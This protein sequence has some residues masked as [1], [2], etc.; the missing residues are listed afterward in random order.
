MIIFCWC[1]MTRDYVLFLYTFY[2]ACYIYK[3]IYIYMPLENIYMSPEK[4]ILIKTLRRSLERPVQFAIA[5]CYEGTL[6]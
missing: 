4:N 1:G 2:K 5:V 3:Y 6:L